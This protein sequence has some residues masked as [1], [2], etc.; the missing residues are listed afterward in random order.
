MKK[1]YLFLPGLLS[2]LVA[3]TMSSCMRFDDVQ[4]EGIQ[5]MNLG[6]LSVNESTLDMDLVF[7][8]PNRIGGVLSRATG[9]AWIQ[10]IYVGDFSTNKEISIPA[11]GNFSVPVRVSANL[12]EI[13]S[14]ALTLMFKDSLQLRLEGNARMGKGSLRRD[15]PIRYKGKKATLEWINHIR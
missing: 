13:F 8:N 2:L 7:H 9:K 6:K 15:V 12:K 3:L 5:N 14:N 1:F 11:R 4:F 10:D